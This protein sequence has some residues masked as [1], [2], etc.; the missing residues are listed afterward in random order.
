LCLRPWPVFVLG[1]SIGSYIKLNAEHYQ[2][3]SLSASSFYF[4]VHLLLSAIFELM[5]HYIRKTEI[6]VW[7]GWDRHLHTAIGICHL[8]PEPHTGELALRPSSLASGP[9][10]VARAQCRGRVFRFP[11]LSV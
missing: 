10:G 5:L 11:V 1:V 2:L 7:L 8:E 3:L 4:A 9:C 6:K